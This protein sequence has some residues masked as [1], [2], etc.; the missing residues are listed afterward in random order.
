MSAF[1][2]VASISLAIPLLGGSLFLGA[3]VANAQG[4]PTGQHLVDLGGAMGS[5]CVAD[6]SGGVGTGSGTGYIGGT[7]PTVGQAPAAPTD[8]VYAPPVY[9]PPPVAAP[10]VQP[11]QQAPIAAP[12]APV[13]H[14][15]P[16]PAPAA[17]HSTVVAPEPAM[18]PVAP[19]PV[20]ADTTGGAMSAPAADAEAPVVKKEETAPEEAKTSEG[21]KSVDQVAPSVA[22][23]PSTPATSEPSASTSPELDAQNAS[24]NEANARK[25]IT[26]FITGT[27]VLLLCGGLTV[28]LIN[29]HRKATEKLR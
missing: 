15:A 3:G 20:V 18:A 7:A 14:A 10:N 22:P 2:R 12:P 1:K 13:A 23:S 26:P 16:A 28:F 24:S 5:T 17:Q 27:G 4:C 6:T 21:P 19:A 29:R 25:D 11:V 9:A 8:P